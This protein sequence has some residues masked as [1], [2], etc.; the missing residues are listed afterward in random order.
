MGFSAVG[1]CTAIAMTAC[2]KSAETAAVNEKVSVYLTDDAAAYDNV[3][4]DVK[5]V[6][7][8]VQEGH[9]NEDQGGN[10]DDH[11]DDNDR[12][13]D[14]DHKSKDQYGKWDT[15]AIRQGVY[16]ILKLRNG[17]DTL[18][19]QGTVKGRVRKIRLTLGD[20][21]SIVKNGV[22][23]SLNFHPGVNHYVYVKI[24]NK[25]HDK[26]ADRH[27]GFHIDFDVTN[28]I[29]ELN[30]AFLLKPLVK[31][32]SENNF[33]KVQGKVFPAEA[34]PLVA[35]FNTNDKGAAIP[36]KSGEYKI[37]GLLE[38]TYKMVFKASEG[39]KDTT[40]NDIKVERGKETK[41]PEV[42]LRK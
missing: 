2:N 24:Q 35:I 7:V 10:D 26:I 36:E 17:V 8:K 38:G 37:R 31:P 42:R 21:N 20:K 13:E 32:F 1:L 25:H 16:D 18:F 23:Y 14:N 27:F 6:E 30:A 4:I 40:I 5:Y 29:F 22:S 34:R 39:Y 28:S 11:F 41:I 33:G 15:L 9:R 3:F 12:D 19:A